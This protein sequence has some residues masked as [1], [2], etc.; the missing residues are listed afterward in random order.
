MPS[1][2]FC[3]EP[4]SRGTSGQQHVVKSGSGKQQPVPTTASGSSGRPSASGGSVP[5]GSEQSECR[6]PQ[7]PLP[8][9]AGRQRGPQEQC[10]QLK[11]DHPEGL[12]LS[13]G[14]ST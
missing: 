6:S 9:Q 5:G 14:S 8:L 3:K 7:G 1:G 13:Y 2:S 12:V 4:G 11:S 10:P